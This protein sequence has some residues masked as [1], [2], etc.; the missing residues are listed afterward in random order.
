MT[1]TFKCQDVEP[2]IFTIDRYNEKQVADLSEESFLLK[3]L[4]IGF[5]GGIEAANINL[6]AGDG[7]MPWFWNGVELKKNPLMMAMLEAYNRHWEMVFAPDDIWLTI[8]GGFAKHIEL[9]AEE[10]RP[11]FVD[12]P[13]QKYIEVRR[14]AFVKGAPDNDWPGAFAEFSDKIGEFIGK[15]RDLIVSDFSTT[16]PIEK[17][18]SEVVLLDA[19]KQYF[20]YGMRTC[21]GFSKVTLLGDTSDWENIKQRVR[22]LSEYGLEWWTRH[23][24]PTIDQ[25]I[26]AA[27]GNIDTEWWKRCVNRHGGSGRDDVSGWALTLFP[28]LGVNSEKN[29][30][31]DWEAEPY[32]GPDVSKF[33]QGLASAPFAWHCYESDFKMEFMGGLMAPALDVTGQRV[34]A[35]TGWAIRDAGDS[36]EG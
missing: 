24:E 8:A 32:R 17:A 10:L 26:A 3:S 2:A 11:Q 5:N 14:D 27:K 1:T 19:M 13:G 22:A 34:R 33:T 28:Y 4:N 23:L 18:A 16:G 30:Y 6:G 31:L 35:A 25:F 15:K 20:T 12:W 7:W 9:N 29:K 21:S 36:I